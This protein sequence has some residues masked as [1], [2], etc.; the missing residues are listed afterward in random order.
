M[1]SQVARSLPS[2]WVLFVYAGGF[3]A[4]AAAHGIDIWQ[5]GLF[6]YRTAPYVLNVFWTSLFLAD[7]FVVLL[8]PF[9]SRA[10]TAVAVAIMACD[11][12]VDVYASHAVWHRNV[13][14]NVRMLGILAFAAFVFAT[15]PAQLKRS[16]AVG[17]FNRR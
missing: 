5:R 10:A 13:L 9:R 12:A 15:A 4:G 11:V 6:P 8:L 3:I 1:D 17:A 16:L 14:T 2:K 7:L